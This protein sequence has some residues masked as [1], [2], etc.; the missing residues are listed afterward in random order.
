MICGILVYHSYFESLYSEIHERSL[1]WTGYHQCKTA[2]N[3]NS[4]VA[5]IWLLEKNSRLQQ[6]YLYFK[7]IS[8]QIRLLGKVSYMGDSDNAVDTWLIITIWFTFQHCAAH[9]HI[10]NLYD[11]IKWVTHRVFFSKAN[12][13]QKAAV[14]LYGLYKHNPSPAK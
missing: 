3:I 12:F 10:S 1:S 9:K 2:T 5:I 11:I 7:S 14:P 13:A 8:L 4:P 6:S